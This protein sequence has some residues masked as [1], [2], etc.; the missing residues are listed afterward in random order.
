VLP[1][2][3]DLPPLSRA[4]FFRDESEGCTE[5]DRA[6]QDPIAPGTKCTKPQ[7]FSG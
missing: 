1:S 2:E 7:E 6:L 4:D 5:G 3:Q